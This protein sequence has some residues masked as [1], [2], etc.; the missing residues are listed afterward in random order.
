[1]KIKDVYKKINEENLTN[2]E[3]IFLYNL[4]EVKGKEIYENLIL[5]NNLT[6]D[7]TLSNIPLNNFYDMNEC[8]ISALGIYCENNLNLNY[9]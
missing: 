8:E 5:K 9:L 2:E 7:K 4:I 1:M 6:N 3:I